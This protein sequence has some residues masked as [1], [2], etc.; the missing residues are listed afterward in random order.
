MGAISELSSNSASLDFLLRE[1][2]QALLQHLFNTKAWELPAARAASGSTSSSRASARGRSGGFPSSPPAPHPSSGA[3]ALGIPAPAGPC[4]RLPQ[5]SHA[6]SSLRQPPI[7]QEQ[8]E[9][10]GASWRERRKR[11]RRRRRTR[12]RRRGRGRESRRE[13]RERERTATAAAAAAAA[14]AA[15][16]IERVWGERASEQ[17]SQPAGR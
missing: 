7:H 16:G 2:Q 6:L 3:A 11:R 10:K 15:G 9:W 8:E 14:A 13:A 5:T 12:R 1:A 17:A 4:P